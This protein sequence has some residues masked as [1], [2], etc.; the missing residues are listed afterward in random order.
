MAYERNMNPL[1]T[2]PR[3]SNARK[4]GRVRSATITCNLGEVADISASGMKVRT[5]TKPAYKPGEA[6]TITVNGV[7][8]SFDVK[9]TFAWSRRNSLFKWT[10]GF[11]L[12]ELS[13]EAR[14]ELLEIARISAIGETMRPV[15]EHVHK[16]H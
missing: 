13:D 5:A 14:Q 9:A 8:R 1:P 4:H 2:P 7:N 6:V 15:S 11:K 3:P 12:G 16:P 10:V